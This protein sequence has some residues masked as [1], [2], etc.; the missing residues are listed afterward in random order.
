MAPNAPTLVL[1]PGRRRAIVGAL[2]VGTFL[3]S[4]EVMVVSP[5]MPAVVADFGGA[6]LYP[7]VFSSYI[8][9]QTL[10][11]PLY[12]RMADRLGRRD[13]YLLGLGLF[14]LGS[15]ACATA[16][17]MPGMVGARL[18]QGLG[19][20]ALVP[21][22]MTL[23]GD[24]Y[25]VADRTRMQGIFSLVWGLSSLLGPVLGGSLTEGFGWRSIFWINLL[26][27]AVAG[28]L[29]L[30]LLPRRLGI[31]AERG[32][33]F[34]ATTWRLLQDPTQ[35][36]IFLAGLALGATLMGVVG[37]LPVQIQAVLGGSAL[38]AG[39]ALI[40]LSVAWT[41]AANLTGRL[42]DRVGFGR[43]VRAGSL[44]VVLG[45]GIAAWD[46]ANAWGLGLVGVGMGITVSSFNVSA[47]IAAPK[48]LV[49][50]A[51]ALTL[52]ARSLGSAAGVT[53]FGALAGMEPAARG[54]AE[55]ADLERGVA[56]VFVAT[57]LMALLSLAMVY[58]RFPRQVSGG[59]SRSGATV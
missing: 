25:A 5:A 22:T 2:L 57:A 55:I 16:G 7:W 50:Q 36:A 40:P 19:A 42:V 43:L 58:L 11:M 13:S 27:G 53:A 32:P 14:V 33:G 35:Q 31:G 49:G 3:A 51:T 59:G 48:G 38:D 47:Q 1:S 23:F 45:T 8:L 34:W 44:V 21:L 6:G 18:V 15:V 39:L 10:S 29:V 52:L 12:G 30:A 46:T 37:Y 28:G 26:P 41:L 17:S 56:R 54:F 24:L 9:A 4:L 20:G